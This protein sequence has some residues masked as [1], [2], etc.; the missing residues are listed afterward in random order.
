MKNTI[1]L[2]LIFGGLLAYAQT[3][4]LIFE[5]D[6]TIVGEIKSMDRGVV[7]I[8]TEYSDS[9][10]NI[11]WKKVKKIYTSTEFLITLED[12]I[13]YFGPIHSVS[14]STVKISTV[15]GMSF[16]YPIIE[17]VYLSPLEKS[18]ADR[19]DASIAFGLDIAKAQN[20]RSLTTRS[21]FG[22]K[23]ERWKSKGSFNTLQSEQDE[24]DR[25]E[26][27]D[28][29]LDFSYILKR[30]W[31]A[32]ANMNTL[33]NTQLSLSYRINTLIGLGNYLVR[34]NFS[35]LRADV[36]LNR[37]QE[38][39]STE[40][41]RTNSL[42]GYVG[43]EINLYDIG[44]LNLLFQLYG[45]PGLTQKDRFRSDMTFDMKYDLPLDFFITLGVS[46]NY[47]NQPAEGAEEVD[48]VISTSFGWEW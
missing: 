32:V 45:Y 29:S 2:F 43:T 46:L 31:Y 24:T 48:Y 7:R 23:A 13:K 40:T 3:D 33:S 36:G 21:S 9:D 5:D 15:L 25:I 14:D 6:Q 20:L 38:K 34:T 28:A 44:D 35:Y 1:S 22:Y 11:E 39:Y 26:R 16:E 17:V 8:E 27:Q 42:E 30:R 4:T 47:D 19:F 41:E 18:F 37:N 12:G 10:F